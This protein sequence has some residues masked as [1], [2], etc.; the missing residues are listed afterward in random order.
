MYKNSRLQ[1]F[2][3]EIDVLKVFT[4]INSGW[5]CYLKKHQFY[6]YCLTR[7]KKETY[8]FCD[9][10]TKRS[11]S[12]WLAKSGF[13]KKN[14]INIFS[15]LLH[16]DKEKITYFYLSNKHRHICLVIENGKKKIIFLV[17]SDAIINHKFK[18]N[19]QNN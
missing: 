18:K 14:T 7:H 1:R 2:S 13:G 5:C 15:I 3:K 10:E 12:I 9:L 19:L 17:K 11:I 4:W 16:R 6:E 8:T